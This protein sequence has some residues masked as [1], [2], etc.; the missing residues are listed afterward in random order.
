MALEVLLTIFFGAVSALAAVWS[1]IMAHRANRAAD[2]AFRAAIAPVVTFSQERSGDPWIIRNDG[3]GPAI[4]VRVQGRSADGRLSQAFI[5][6]SIGA[7]AE[8]KNKTDCAD[9]L[10]ALYSD[11]DGNLYVTKCGA[12]QNSITQ[13]VPK[14]QLAKMTD[15]WQLDKCVPAVER[16]GRQ[17]L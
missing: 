14:N 10:M 9:E 3:K 15:G 12:N 7:G 4:N 8:R 2:R 13:A 11:S 16:R 17:P 6:H 1:T 5:Y